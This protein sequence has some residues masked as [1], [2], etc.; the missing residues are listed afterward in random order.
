M[1]KENVFESDTPTIEME[2][3]TMRS[4]QHGQ[5][6]PVVSG[7]PINPFTGFA[8]NPSSS[9]F[10]QQAGYGNFTGF[11]APQT[12][13]QYIANPAANQAQQSYPYGGAFTQP[14]IAGAFN[15]GFYGNAF[16]T[17]FISN[18]FPGSY[19]S[20]PFTPI[21]AQFGS[22]PFA[23][24]FTGQFAGSPSTQPNF[25]S[26]YPTQSSAY[27]QPAINIADGQ[28]ML[29]PYQTS[30]SASKNGA[31]YS[32]TG[33]RDF[34]SWFPNVNILETDRT[35]K[36]EICVPGVTKENCRISV[37][38]N[39][40]LRITGSRRWNQE[41][42]AV[43]FTRKEFNYGTFSC[44][45]V[46]TENL[47]KERISSSCRNGLLIIGIPKKEESEGGEKSSSDISVN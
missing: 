30:Q 12:S 16:P 10:S 18:Q 28:Y 24:P 26:G 38:K 34:I 25:S 37:D 47:Q 15:P 27:Y 20:N 43:G 41:T 9:P 29:V 8:I 4:T 21:S 42:D 19:A 17:P 3:Q 31:A 45:F 40:I 6:I 5:P 22:S 13:P 39:N 33:E 32:K 14:A 7:I 23:T 11:T 36:I 1:K 46:L 2:T 44:S 35:F